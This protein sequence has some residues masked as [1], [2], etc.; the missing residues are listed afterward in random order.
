MKKEENRDHIYRSGIMMGPE[1]RIWA[2]LCLL[3]IASSDKVVC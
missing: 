1:D 2:E 3:R